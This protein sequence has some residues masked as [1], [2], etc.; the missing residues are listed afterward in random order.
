MQDISFDANGH[1]SEQK[2]L[3]KRISEQDFSRGLKN[4]RL[5]RTL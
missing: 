1:Q 4:G 5:Q 2:F 3:E